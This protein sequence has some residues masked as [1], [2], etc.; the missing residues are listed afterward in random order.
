MMQ[1]RTLRHCLVGALPVLVAC[2]AHAQADYSVY[3]VADFSYGRFEPSGE[4]R[5]HRFNS[6]SMSASFVGANA[7][8]AFE[9]GWTQIGRAHV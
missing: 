8:Y 7:K 2:A 3:G 9:G 6:N 1:L 4:Y 5:E